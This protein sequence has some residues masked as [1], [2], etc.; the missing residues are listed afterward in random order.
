MPED[1]SSEQDA[2]TEDTMTQEEQEALFNDIDP[3]NPEAEDDDEGEEDV[4]ETEDEDGEDVD[5]ESEDD[6][7]DD[8][9]ED[10]D[11]EDDDDDD[12]DDD[13]EGSAAEELKKLI[14]KNKSANAETELSSQVEARV[15][16]REDAIR[17]EVR[18]EFI[19][20]KE[21]EGTDGEK[22]NLD[23]MR[24]EYGELFGAV[25]AISLNLANDMM[26]KALAAGQFV[27][28]EDFNVMQGERETEKFISALEK[29]HPDL[30]VADI[31]TNG[32]HAFWAWH[33]KQEADVQ[34]LM[35]P[36][37]QTVAGV[38]A[39]FKAYK[40]ATVKN[41]NKTIDKGAAKKKKKHTDLHGTTS[42]TERRSR[43][44]KAGK[45][46]ERPMTAK[47]QQKTFDDYK[48]TD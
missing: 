21:I 25:E 38:S 42:R 6:D 22:I 2:S 45:G 23:E 20:K 36:E 47:E 41:S 9:D 29:Q 28:R 17:K 4:E 13:D 16:E 7:E 30:D 3:D 24:E 43:K 27:S 26:Q 31:N 15:K 19:G 18:E 44:A 48:V 11:D 39:M 1:K 12:E 33:D 8:S 32:E 10:D 40:E 46:E 35:K 14:A 5:D 37:N 34:N